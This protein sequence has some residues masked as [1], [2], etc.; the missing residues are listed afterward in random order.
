MKKSDFYFDLPQ[1]L[2]AQTPLQKRDSSRLLCLGKESG[3]ITHEHFFNLPE[4]LVPGDCL[5]LNN[6]CSENGTPFLAGGYVH[7]SVKPPLIQ[8]F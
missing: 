3:E 7:H 6:I 4:H 2:I 5:V 1:E 8:F